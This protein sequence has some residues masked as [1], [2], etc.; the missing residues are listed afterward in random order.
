MQDWPKWLLWVKFFFFKSAWIFACAFQLNILLSFFSWNALV[1]HCCIHCAGFNILSSFFSETKCKPAKKQG[2]VLLLN[3]KAHA[4]IQALL[5]KN[6]HP[7]KSLR[8]VLHQ[9]IQLDTGPVKGWGR[10]GWEL[11]HFTPTPLPNFPCPNPP[12]VSN[13]SDGLIWKCA[14]ACLKYTCTAG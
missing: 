11:D 14:L 8:S 9:A 6:I 12:Q 5:K 2:D 3:W 4:K 7:K 13:P 1:P 10:E